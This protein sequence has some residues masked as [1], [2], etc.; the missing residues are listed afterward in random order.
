[1]NQEQMNQLLY[2]ALETELGGVKVYKTALR[3][4]VN[5]DLKEEWEEYLEQ[6]ENHVK[7]VLKLF[8]EL[9]LDPEKETPGRKV[10]R[11]IGGSLVEAMEMALSAGN[12]GA[13]ELVACEC[14]VNAETKDHLNW[15]LIGELSKKVKG[16]PAKALKKAHDEV[17]DEEDEHLYHT[18]GWCRELWIDSLGLPAV[19]PPPEEEKDV[20]TAI[21]AA[22]AKGSRK[23]LLKK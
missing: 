21:G 5:K 17:E 20:K 9:G 18:A 4:V 23:E 1:M 13:A 16:E 10:V 3:C 2:E 22:R 14:V 6:T 19:L 11:K 8:D 12:R 7:V 15:E